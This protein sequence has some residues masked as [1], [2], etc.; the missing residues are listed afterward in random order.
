[1]PPSFGSCFKAGFKVSCAALFSFQLRFKFRGLHLRVLA[2][3]FGCLKKVLRLVEAA[4]S[5]S[6][7]SGLT[8]RAANDNAGGGTWSQVSFGVTAGT[9]YRIAVDGYNG[10][11]GATRLTG[12]FTASTPTPTPTPTPSAQRCGSTKAQRRAR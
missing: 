5:G 12:T 6:A 2:V 8:Q 11:T 1:M 4:Y 7:V 3:S 10:A 9:V